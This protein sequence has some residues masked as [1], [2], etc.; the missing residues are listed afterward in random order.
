M[1]TN[2]PQVPSSASVSNLMLHVGYALVPGTL[3]YIWLFGIGVLVQIL[4]ACV[5]A[6]ITEG[7]ILILRKRPV[8]QTLADGSAL[9][10]AVLLALAISP[11]APWWIIVLGTAFA[12]IFGKQLYGGIG[13][14]PFN[15]AMLG[16]VML[17]ISFPLEM[18]NW[19]AAFSLLEQTPT[20]Q[21]SLD[22]IFNA[23]L[24]ID[25]V[26]GATPLDAIKTQLAQGL[27]IPA[28]LISPSYGE[29]F[30]TLAG[31]GWE[32]VSIGF[33]LG[34][35]YLLF[36]GRIAWQIPAAMLGSIAVLSSVF[37]LIDSTQYISP[38]LHL[39]GGASML[40]AF[41]I[42]T[43]PVSAATTPRGRIYY[44]IGIGI[45]TFVIRTWG[46]YPEGLAFA[47]LLMNMAAPTI[48]HYT[49]PTVFGQGKS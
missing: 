43:D 45:F 33:L 37:Y 15:P 16:Y 6:V 11:I 36:T 8:A 26:S 23:G 2:T 27:D 5:T 34:G 38:L 4:L 12:I 14:N 25:T 21:T 47:V 49:R 9:L 13:Y 24:G 10:T 42:A 46:G 17:L 44:G 30:G 32:V 19:P 39:F 20:F 7:L 1:T 31:V 3:A 35:I 40:G 29:L 48:D 41:F 18:T 22:V 28:T